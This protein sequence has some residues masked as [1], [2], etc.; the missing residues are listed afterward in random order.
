MREALVSGNG[1]LVRLDELGNPRVDLLMVNLGLAGVTD[2]M[3]MLKE[4]NESLKII[5]LENLEARLTTNIRVDGRL[6]KQAPSEVAQVDEWLRMIKQ[7]LVD[8]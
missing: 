6:R 5:S 1:L 4:R 8:V 2:I 7:L 3:A